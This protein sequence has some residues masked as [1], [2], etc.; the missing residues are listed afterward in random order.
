MFDF[1]RRRRQPGSTKRSAYD[2]LLKMET[3]YQ[4]RITEL[5]RKIEKQQQH[6][7]EILEKGKR[8]ISELA[9][10]GLAEQY[11]RGERQ[12]HRLLDRR[13]MLV[14]AQ[15]LVEVQLAH[16]D[17]HAT[18]PE[19]VLNLNRP[20]A[21]RERALA[22]MVRERLDQAYDEMLSGFENSTTESQNDA[23]EKAAVQAV[24]ELFDRERDEEI[25]L[26][27]Q[28]IEQ[29]LEATTSDVRYARSDQRIR[30]AA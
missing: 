9:R 26:T 29:D 4:L 8:E 5:N 16:L 20:E 15:E 23:H 19:E 28:A 18:I 25:R 21:Q 14:K 12:V 11:A 7:R 1:L 3:D 10:L 17:L 2:E 24:L 22:D 30:E 27:L 13:K 6:Q